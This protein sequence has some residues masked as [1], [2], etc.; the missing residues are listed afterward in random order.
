MN[1]WNVIKA[2]IS[3]S[4][5]GQF[6]VQGRQALAGLQAW[7][8]DVNRS[9][10]IPL[11]PGSAGLKVDLV[12]YDDASIARQACAV[13]E[14]LILKDRVDL[15]FGPYSSVLA[16]TSAVVAEEHSRVMWNQGGASDD[17]YEQGYRYVVGILSLIHI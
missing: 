14:R 13:T 12:H 2:G 9:G 6:H 17:V 3:V 1:R 5:T 10:G 16:S 7:I 11:S 8:D 15:L 4:L